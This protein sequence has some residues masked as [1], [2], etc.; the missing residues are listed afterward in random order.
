M[1]YAEPD[2]YGKFKCT[3]EKCRHSCCI[4]WEIDIDDDKSIVKAVKSVVKKDSPCAI[5]GATGVVLL[6]TA[7][8]IKS[9]GLSMPYDV[10][11]CGFDDWSW[12]SGVSWAELFTPG[13]TTFVASSRKIGEKAVEL[14]LERMVNP[15]APTQS[16]YIST[17]FNE[18]GSTKLK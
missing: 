3:A 2:F 5:I 12:S 6:H 1:V 11:L 13:I 10:G 8:V 17:K 9:L 4:G 7:A 16:V 18:R 15:D 14:L